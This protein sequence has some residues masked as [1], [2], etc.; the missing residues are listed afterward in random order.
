MD[1]NFHQNGARAPR[2]IVWALLFSAAIAQLA[3]AQATVLE[4][5]ALRYRTAEEVIPLIRPMLAREGS[6]SGLKG[7]LVVRT[8]PANLEEIR[9]ILAALD[10]APRQLLITVRQEVDAGRS[11]RE[12]ELAGRIGGERARMSVPDSGERR[13]AGIEL[14]EGDDRVRARVFD[15]RS[16]AG[17]SGVQ[18]VRVIEGREAFVR[19]GQ[20]VPVRERQVQRTVVGGRVVEQVVEATQYREVTTGF[21]VLARLA[22]DRVMLEVSPQR[23][24]LSTEIPRGVDLQRVATTVSGRLG[25]WI[26]IGGALQELER[27]ESVL[28][29]RTA[30]AGSE[31]RRVLIK[32]E[33]VP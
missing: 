15:S 9:R 2:R 1:G 25:E 21:H 12:A 19:I 11:A 18:S 14:R 10:V 32:V 30:I 29:G 3:L 20:A 5:I 6:V 22:G 24:A 26:E 16:A 23:E 13:G 33:E 4:V 31:R 17:E 27:R 7:Q 28:L 8:T